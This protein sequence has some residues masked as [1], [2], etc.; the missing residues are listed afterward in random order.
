[1]YGARVAQKR[2][3]RFMNRYFNIA[4][5]ALICLSACAQN[6]KNEWENL[7]Y[8]RIARENHQREN[9]SGYVQ[10]TVQGCVDDDLYNCPAGKHYY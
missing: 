4:F 7:D 9:D 6:G 1:M 3:K 5:L 8:S 2:K 10:P